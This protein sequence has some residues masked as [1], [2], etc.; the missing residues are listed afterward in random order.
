MIDET[1]FFSA[2]AALSE[3]GFWAG[4]LFESINRLIRDN[5]RLRANMIGVKLQFMVE[6]WYTSGPDCRLF[7][8]LG[9]SET[10]YNMWVE[11]RLS[12]IQFYD[13]CDQR[14][15]GHLFIAEL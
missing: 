9:A 15:A 4:S 13:Q 8:W 1:D 7:E 3:N 6:S 2:K 10:I 12:D 14:S 11:G 5:A